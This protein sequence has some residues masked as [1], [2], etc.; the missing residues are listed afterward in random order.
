L[1]AVRL[2]HLLDRRGVD[3]NGLVDAKPLFCS[4]KRIIGLLL[5]TNA[6]SFGGVWVAAAVGQLLHQATKGVIGSPC[7][8]WCF[9]EFVARIR[10]GLCAAPACASDDSQRNHPP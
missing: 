7:R 10:D 2:R 8:A 9:S 3:A 5:R 6:L 4:G 1:H